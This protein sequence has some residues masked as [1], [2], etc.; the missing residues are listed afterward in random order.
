EGAAWQVSEASENIALQ[1]AEVYLDIFHR[2]NQLELAKDNLVVHQKILDQIEVLMDSGAGRKADLK[3][4]EGR[5]ALAK[6]SLVDAQG[7]LRDTQFNY[8]RVT[9]EPAEGLELPDAA[10]IKNE[11]PTTLE[12]ALDDAI[13]MH[14]TMRSAES[15]LT[16]ARVIRKQSRSSYFPRIDLEVEASRNDNLDGIAFEN[17]DVA[18]M[19]RLRYNLYRGGADRAR[20]RETANLVEAARESS[21]RARRIVEEEVRLAWNSLITIRDRLEHLQ[22]HVKSSEEVLE[23]YRQQFKLGQRSLLDV[24]DSENELFGARSA[25]KNAEYAE[26]FSMYRVLAGQGKLLKILGVK[27]S[28]QA[29]VGGK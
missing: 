15:R 1:T 2:E 26:L 11:I 8:L 9:G 12:A 13:E 4:A 22:Q 10:A 20:Q 17:N 14:P 29:M 16:A 5:L 21:N 28:D 19:L 25:L 3:Q 23:A 7:R 24:L 6:S 18:A 27:K